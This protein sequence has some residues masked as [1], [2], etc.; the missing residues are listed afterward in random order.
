MPPGGKRRAIDGESAYKNL[1]QWINK[2]K[3]AFVVVIT[4][5]YVDQKLRERFI[6][7]IHNRFAML[8][9]PLSEVEQLCEGMLTSEDFGKYFLLEHL[10]KF[11]LDHVETLKDLIKERDSKISELE[12]T[13]EGLKKKVS[14]LESNTHVPNRDSYA[15]VLSSVHHTPNE[16]EC[17]I[18]RSR[19]EK[20]KIFVTDETLNP[21]STLSKVE[22]VLLDIVPVKKTI[23]QSTSRGVMLSWSD[24]ENY[25]KARDALHQ[26]RQEKK[27]S[28]RKPTRL[29]PRVK[30]VGV[31]TSL[32]EESERKDFLENLSQYNPHIFQKCPTIG[33]VRA[34]RDLL[35]VFINVSP[36]EYAILAKEK[37]VYYKLRS[38]RVF[39]D[40]AIPECYQCLAIGHVK[41]NCPACPICKLIHR[42]ICKQ[43]TTVNICLNCNGKDGHLAKDCQ[44]SPVC[45]PCVSL[46][47]DSRHRRLER[48]VCPTRQRF[49]DRKKRMVDFSGDDD[50]EEDEEGIFD[51]GFDTTIVA[52]DSTSAEGSTGPNIVNV[53]QSTPQHLYPPRTFTQ[54]GQRNQTRERTGFRNQSNTLSSNRFNPLVGS[55]QSDW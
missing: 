15:S 34:R 53:T 5:N 29:T 44:K 17:R 22:S 32:R 20:F 10:E 36:T 11:Q 12:S 4:P 8:D 21:K 27:F 50:M 52:R 16:V 23:V 42:G 40:D 46:G 6:T 1:H 24:K 35:D 18:S 54:K 7:E 51:S 3:N 47:L 25:V 43:G 45:G 19:E 55:L 13:I 39:D 33:Q 2:I 31:D 9:Q 48:G 49:L 41:K 26:A 28:M 30:I 38:F 37:R 14:T